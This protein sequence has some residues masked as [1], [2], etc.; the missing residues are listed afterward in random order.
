MRG[1]PAVWPAPARRACEMA[2]SLSRSH[3]RLAKGRFAKETHQHR[4]RGRRGSARSPCRRARAGAV[5]NLSGP[6]L[7]PFRRTRSAAACSCAQRRPS[8][9]RRLEAAKRVLWCSQASRSRMPGQRRGLAG[10]ADED[11]LGHFTQHGAGRRRPGARRLSTPGPHGAARVRRRPV[12]SG[13]A[14][15]A[16]EVRH[17]PWGWLPVYIPPQPNRTKKCARRQLGGR[18]KYWDPQPRTD[19]L[20]PGIELKNDRNLHAR[21][22]GDTIL[23]ARPKPPFA[24]CLD[25]ALFK[26]RPRG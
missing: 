3:L 9:R 5:P 17:H 24:D 12:R 26:L 7:P 25:C 10:Q 20:F 8:S 11:H 2:F 4:L 14:R 22:H 16:R 21:V 6:P 15:S 1:R 19:G 18:R 23:T 13:F